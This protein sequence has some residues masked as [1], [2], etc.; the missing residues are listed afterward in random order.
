MGSDLF[1]FLELGFHANR[2][3]SQVHKHGSKSEEYLT[4]LE[5]VEARSRDEKVQLTGHS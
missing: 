4:V 1:F 3:A 5:A 2:L